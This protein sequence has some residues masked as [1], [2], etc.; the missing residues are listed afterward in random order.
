MDVCGCG[1]IAQTRAGTVQRDEVDYCAA[2]GLPVKITIPEDW[3]PPATKSIHIPEEGFEPILTGTCSCGLI[4]Q[5]RNGGP[6]EIDGRVFCRACHKP[7]EAITSPSGGSAESSALSHDS[8]LRESSDP[9]PGWY[10]NPEDPQTLRLWDGKAWT[11][12]TRE[13]P[14]PPPEGS[15]VE[16]YLPPP[17]GRPVMVGESI[18]KGPAPGSG[19]AYAGS[20]QSPRPFV[21]ITAQSPPVEPDTKVPRRNDRGPLVL[22]I[23]ALLLGPLP[24]LWPLPFIAVVWSARQFIKAPKETRTMLGWALGISIASVFWFAIVKIAQSVNG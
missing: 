3:S 17:T 2:C 5:S 15:P 7:L 9:I 10:D 21:G 16:P 18:S 8:Q 24:F 23:L 1:L 11:S 22:A 6:I 14:L 13:R 19:A 12:Q 20:T 4:R